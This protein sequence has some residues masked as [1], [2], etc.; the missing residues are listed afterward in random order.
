MKSFRS[1]LSFEF[2][3]NL[4]NYYCFRYDF[5]RSFI[6]GKGFRAEQILLKSIPQYFEYERVDELELWKI[7]KI[8][9][10]KLLFSSPWSVPSP[11]WVLLGNDTQ[12]II[13]AKPRLNNELWTFFKWFCNYWA[14]SFFVYTPYCIR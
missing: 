14:P 9:W 10:Y 8:S 12:L 2:T 11:S 7:V 1:D 3:S 6:V 5:A 13:S 4:N